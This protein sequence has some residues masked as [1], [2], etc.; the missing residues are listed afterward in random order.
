MSLVIEQSDY[1]GFGFRACIWKL[2]Y[3]SYIHV[4]SNSCTDIN[5]VHNVVCGL[6]IDRMSLE[7]VVTKSFVSNCTENMREDAPSES[8]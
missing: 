3:S 2:I 7:Y 6:D 4:Y 8:M 5:Y 1:S